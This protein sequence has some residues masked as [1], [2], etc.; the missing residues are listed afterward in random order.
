MRRSRAATLPMEPI[1]LLPERATDAYIAAQVRA[2]LSAHQ[3]PLNSFQA[4]SLRRTLVQHILAV[5]LELAELRQ[6]VA[7]N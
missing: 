5:E 3:V 2:A 7:E 1:A 4:A 6:K